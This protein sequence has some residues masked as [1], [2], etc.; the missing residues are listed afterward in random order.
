MP[1]TTKH[2]LTP[3]PSHP[4]NNRSQIRSLSLLHPLDKLR[5]TLDDL[6]PSGA[7]VSV[8]P[9]TKLA[10]LPGLPRV[11]KGPT[12]W[13][14]GFIHVDDLSPLDPDHGTFSANI[15]LKQ[16]PSASSFATKSSPGMLNIWP[17]KWN[18][19]DFY[20]NASTLSALTT[21]DAELQQRLRMKLGKPVTLDVQASCATQC[22]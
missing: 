12:R 2:S 17:C 11:M 21:Q 20:K 10:N 3:S 4:Q 14:S 8:D 15:Y 6:H 16:P 19:M 13:R 7:G 22:H 18:K 9:I 5:L 1:T